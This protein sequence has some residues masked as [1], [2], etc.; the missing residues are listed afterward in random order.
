M[1]VCVRVGGVEDSTHHD[2]QTHIG[3]KA[4]FTLQDE[5]V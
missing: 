5:H 3:G 1:V 4:R 2:L